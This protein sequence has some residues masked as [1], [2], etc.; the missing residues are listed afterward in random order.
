MSLGKIYGYD[1]RVNNNVY[2]TEV[3]PSEVDEFLSDKVN[4]CLVK[5]CIYQSDH[6]ANETN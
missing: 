4:F 6:K 3:V 2:L 1:P 5:F